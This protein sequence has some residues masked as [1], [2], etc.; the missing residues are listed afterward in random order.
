MRLIPLALLLS[1]CV[2]TPDLTQGPGT[3]ETPFG[4]LWYNVVGEGD[5]TPSILLHGGPGFNSYYL[6]PM[7]A[8]G[9]VARVY[10]FDRGDVE[11]MRRLAAH[12]RLDP[13]WRA[14]FE[15]QLAGSRGDM[16]G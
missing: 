15:E 16:A 9:E 5:G 13:T 14:Y 11:T 8:L 3:L 6:N 7:A 4:Q 10:A 1:A 2:A 12:E